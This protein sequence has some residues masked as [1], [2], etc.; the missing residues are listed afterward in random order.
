MESEEKILHYQSIYRASADANRTKHNVIRVTGD[1]KVSVQPNKAEITLGVSTEDQTLVKAQENNAII[2]S[3]IRKALNQIGITDEQMK[4]IDY[5]ISPQ[6]DYTEG[7]QVFRNYKVEHLLHITMNQIE[8]TGLVVDTAVSNGANIVLG[9]KFDTSD[10]DQY[11]QQALALAVLNAGQKAETIANTL[12]VQL[13]KA[14]ILVVENAQQQGG[15]IPY[16]TT[17]FVSSEAVTPIL[18]STIDIN[19][20]VTA[21]FTYIS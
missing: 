21:E 8:N 11:Y 13:T 3:K 5:S 10:Y 17:A 1:G 18:P 16:K 2:I 15:P 4:T 19:S 6:Y 20:R 14:P 7:K 12:R 9:I